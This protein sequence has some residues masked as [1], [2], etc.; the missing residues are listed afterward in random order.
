MYQHFLVLEKSYNDM[1]WAQI[2]ERYRHYWTCHHPNQKRIP[3]FLCISNYLNK[4]S[5]VTVEVYE[6]LWKFM[7]VQAD[8]SWKGMYQDLYDKAKKIITKVA[9]IKFYDTLKPLYLEM[10]ASGIDLGAGLLQVR[11]GM[12][13]GHDKVPDNANPPAECIFK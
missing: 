3:S 9:C 11:K 10:D 6:A 2:L 1:M 8:L 4:F 12:T 7:S 5:A 13:C